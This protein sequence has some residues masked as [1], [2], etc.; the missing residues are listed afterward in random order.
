MPDW[1]PYED[2][3][4]YYMAKKE[5][6]GGALLD[7]S[8]GIDLMRYIL[9]EVKGVFA[10]VDT[11]SDLEIST[12]DAAFLTLR[13]QSGALAHINFDLQSRHARIN[14]ELIGTKGNILWDR[15]EHSIKVYDVERKSWEVFNYNINTLLSMYQT[16]A[17][18]FIKCVRG[19]A[20]SIIDIEDALKTQK[21]VDAAFASS[22]SGKYMELN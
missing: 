9:G 20:K 5:Q 18:H 16:Q 6:G 2:Y 8:H 14:F 19:E 7:E 15:M 22:D 4:T 13:L 10:I 17:Q 3:R 12:D 21:V 1:H 11:I